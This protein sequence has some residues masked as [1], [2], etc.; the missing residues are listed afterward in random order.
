M[1][2][3]PPDN[4]SLGL[5]RFLGWRFLTGIVI[6]LFIVTLWFLVSPLIAIA[7]PVF[8]II[9]FPELAGM[10]TRVRRQRAAVIL[11]YLEQAARLNLPLPAML[12]AARQ[13]EEGLTAERLAGVQGLLEKGTSVATALQLET[14]EV[15]R[16]YVSL[17]G[18]AER[19]G[20]LPQA[21]ARIMN[22]ERDTPEQAERMAFGRWYPLLMSLVLLSVGWMLVIF[23]IPKTEEIC[24]DFGLRLPYATQT[25]VDLSRA[26]AHAEIGDAPL[27]LIV[28][29]GLVLIFL[30]GI[31]ERIWMPRREASQE[32]FLDRLAWWLPVWH[33]IARNRGLADTCDTL[34]GAVRAGQP[35]PLAVEEAARIRM[36]P[37]LR[38]RLLRWNAGLLS[39][40]PA[41]QAARD[42][43]LPP[44]FCG[45][46]GAGHGEVPAQSL[47][48]LAA[49][50]HGRFSRSRELVRAAA[51]PVMTLIF[52]GLVLFV[53]A[54]MF[55]PLLQMMEFLG[56]GAL[57]VSK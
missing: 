51:I 29:V 2:E 8:I 11:S 57:K 49:Y 40:K 24:K 30:G 3:M 54:G 13:S 47:E 39:G 6:A 43:R 15:S 37:V 41:D 4:P 45:M 44:L 50:Y 53:A 42:A 5:L 36:N 46:I 14:P 12:D 16:R 10:S 31:F 32:V 35:I 28:T 26:L 9:F 38:D 17:I 27:A 48:F 25:L 33:G 1:T 22:E 20:R 23:V 21:L 7:S 19:V 34:A 18:A 56:N 52:G 55:T